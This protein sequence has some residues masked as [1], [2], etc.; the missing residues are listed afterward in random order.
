MNFF[1]RMIGRGAFLGQAATVAG[2]ALLGKNALAGVDLREEADSLPFKLSLIQTIP[3]ERNNVR[4]LAMDSRGRFLLVGKEGL[5]CIDELG[6]ELRRME[7]SE[8]LMGVAADE[9]D[10]CYLAYRARVEVRDPEGALEREWGERG[11]QPG[12]FLYLTSIAVEGG[13]LAV[14]DAGN[15]KVHHY[16][17]DGDF[18]ESQEGFRVPS[19]Y[20]DCS[21]DSQGNLFLG[22]TSE[23]RVECYDTT[24]TLTGNWGTRGDSLAAFCGCCNP[25]NLA[26]FPDGRVATTEK[27]IPRLKV[28]GPQ[29]DLL[30]ALNPEQLGSHTDSVYLKMLQAGPGAE[31]PCHDG[32]PG[33]PMAIDRQGRLAVSVPSLR[34]VRLYEMVSS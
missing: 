26:V 9:R 20:F 19:A 16:A 5:F 34:Q 4:G 7:T 10:R 32:W 21:F 11:K 31:V 12:Q 29:G 24:R 2:S 14:A 15:R 33:M 30:A 13:H 6:H 17:V 3:V 8:P 23:H 1:R 28:Y 18:I 22:H 25:T 27:G